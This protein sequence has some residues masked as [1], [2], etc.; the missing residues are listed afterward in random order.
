MTSEQQA[1]VGLIGCG[2]IS[3]IYLTNGTRRFAGFDILAVADLV[4]ERA[5]EKA[6][7]Y[8]I[9]RA[10]TP[11]ELIADPGIDIVLNLTIPAAHYAINRAALEAGKAVY[12]EKPIAVDP[13]EGQ[14]LVDLCL[15]YT[16]DA[17][18]DLTRVD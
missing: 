5:E 6:R 7:E 11:D 1:R 2:K 9:P 8:A 12:C 18:D 4:R 14:A 3:D 13:A 16:S 15:L 10:L 17:A